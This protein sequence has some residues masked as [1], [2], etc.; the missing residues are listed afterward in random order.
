MLREIANDFYMNQNYNCGECILRAANKAYDLGLDE[1]ALKL[2]SGFGAGMGCGNTCGALSAAMSVLSLLFCGDKAHETEGFKELC[3]EYVDTFKASLGSDNCEELKAR[4][5][6]PEGD[7]RRCLITVEKAADVLEAFIASHQSEPASDAPSE[8]PVSADEIKR[9]K[10]LGFLNNKGTNR[11]N[12]R[13]VTGNGRITTAQARCIADAA[14]L[15]GSG[16]ITMTT[17]LSQEVIGVEYDK[18]PDFIAY[19]AKEGLETGGTGAK[20]RPVVS[21]KGTTCQY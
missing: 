9:L 21:C 2:A 11:F 15:Y 1:R 6:Y 16:Q 20:I 17:R 3:A 4:Y 12:A 13:V 10:G 18:I 8:T 14:A 7:D 5:R 19:L